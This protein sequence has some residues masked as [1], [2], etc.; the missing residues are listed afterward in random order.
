MTA[1]LAATANYGGLQ[2]PAVSFCS[3]QPDKYATKAELLD[4]FVTC[5]LTLLQLKNRAKPGQQ[6]HCTLSRERPHGS[7]TLTK[8]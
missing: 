7:I 1:P 2:R 5:H 8:L 4:N 6:G 3:N